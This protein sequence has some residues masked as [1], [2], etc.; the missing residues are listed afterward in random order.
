MFYR[1]L[2]ICLIPLILGIDMSRMVVFAGFEL[3]RDYIASKLCENRNKPWMHCN[4]RCYLAK[5]LK[6]AE[7][8]EKKTEKETQKHLV[9]DSSLPECFLMLFRAPR[10]TIVNTPYLYGPTNEFYPLIFQPPRA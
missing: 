5:K 2:A 6:Q 10:I 1:L 8:K 7:E 3:N 9:Q 4:G